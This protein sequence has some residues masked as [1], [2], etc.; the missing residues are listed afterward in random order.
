MVRVRDECK[1]LPIRSPA[2]PIITVR[3]GKELS[4]LTSSRGHNPDVRRLG[5]GFEIDI[6]HAADYPLAVGRNLRLADAL[7]L[8]HVFESERMLGLG[9]GGKCEWDQNE[10]SQEE[11]AHEGLLENQSVET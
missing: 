2:R 9:D 1:A 6:D 7:Q 8:H 10:K 5:V 4:F 3:L 11:T